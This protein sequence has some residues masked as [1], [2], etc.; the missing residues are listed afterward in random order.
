MEDNALKQ[1]VEA[2]T[3]ATE[4]WIDAMLDFYNIKEQS[5]VPLACL[6]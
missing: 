1:L 5:G 6:N 3:K 4:E 2:N